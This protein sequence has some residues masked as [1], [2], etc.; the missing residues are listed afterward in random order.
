MRVPQ[1]PGWPGS[2]GWV[3][4]EVTGMQS[5]L[6]WVARMAFLCS[7]HPQLASGKIYFLGIADARGIYAMQKEVLDLLGLRLHSALLPT[8]GVAVSAD[9]MVF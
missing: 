1:T 7:T 9:A 5:R 8:L 4:A 6:P 2:R 3:A